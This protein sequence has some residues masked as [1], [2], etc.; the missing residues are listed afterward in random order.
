MTRVDEVGPQSTREGAGLS[1]RLTRADLPNG[2]RNVLRGVY[3]DTAFEPGDLPVDLLGRLGTED[4]LP[5]RV[6]FNAYGQRGFQGEH[7]VRKGKA[8]L[9]VSDLGPPVE[10]SV[11]HDRRTPCES[12]SRPSRRDM[13][14]FHVET[15]RTAIP[16][17]VSYLVNGNHRG[18][19][20]LRESVGDGRLAYAQRSKDDD[21][22]AQGASHQS[23]R[24]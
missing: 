21:V 23:W 15:D 4:K 9:E 20:G 2:G 17:L 13:V 16:I 5:V 3:R 6:S 8:P 22:L 1:R 19:D 11:E 10:T 14:R 24:P 7:F 12:R 18:V